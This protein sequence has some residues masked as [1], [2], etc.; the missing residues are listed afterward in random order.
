V[1]RHVIRMCIGYLVYIM[2]TSQLELSDNN[3]S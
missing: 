2:I 1:K 3:K